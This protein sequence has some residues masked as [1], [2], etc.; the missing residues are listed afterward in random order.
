MK[1][2]I[3]SKFVGFFEPI[4]LESLKGMLNLRNGHAENFDLV[5]LGWSW[6]IQISNK[7]SGAADTA[8]LG[9]HFENH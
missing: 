6:R 2:Q 1:N 9:P 4:V 8:F 3:L 7:L 5:D